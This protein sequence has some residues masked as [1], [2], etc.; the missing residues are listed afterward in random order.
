MEYLYHKWPRLC[1]ICR[2]HFPVIY[3][4]MTHHW[5]CNWINTTGAIE[6]A[7]TAY[8][9][10]PHEFHPRLLVGFV[11]LYLC[12]VLSVFRRFKDLDYPFGIFK[13]FLWIRI[14]FRLGVLDIT[15]CDKVCQWL[16]AGWW[17][18]PGTLG[19]V[20][21]SMRNINSKPYWRAMQLTTIKMGIYQVWYTCHVYFFFSIK[22]SE[23]MWLEKH[24]YWILSVN[25]EN[26]LTFCICLFVCFFFLTT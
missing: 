12:V 16:A 19:L 8:P 9:F 2:K 24:L 4:F 7:G 26:V 3:S 15:L 11:L 14:L 20:L 5:V 21:L 17:F 18:S 10:G 23:E 6:G 25:K 22:S 13:L 1:W